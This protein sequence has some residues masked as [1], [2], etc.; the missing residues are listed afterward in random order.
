MC[1]GH[2]EGESVKISRS[3]EF[4]SSGHIPVSNYGLKDSSYTEKVRVKQETD[5][6]QPVGSKRSA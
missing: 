6:I 1:S 3:V 2:R 5:S 4:S